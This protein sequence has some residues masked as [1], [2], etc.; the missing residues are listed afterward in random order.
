MFDTANPL[1]PLRFPV[2]WND[3]RPEHVDAAAQTHLER[4]RQALEDLKRPQDP[5]SNPLEAVESALEDLEALIRLLRLGT[6]TGQGDLRELHARWLPQ[7]SSLRSRVYASSELYRALQA[8]LEACGDDLDALQRRHLTL[9][10]ERLRREGAALSQEQRERLLAIDGRIA[11]LSALFGQNVTDDANR[12]VW[13]FPDD[14]RLAGLPPHALE[15]AREEAAARG[16]E[17][18]LLSLQPH[19]LA[20]VLDHAEDAELR[21]E[22]YLAD[23]STATCDPHDNRPILS[24]MLALRAEKAE[25]LGYPSYADLLLAD[26]MAGNLEAALA[27]EERLEQ[28]LRPAFERERDDL[29]R[30]RRR[31]EGEAAPEPQAWDLRFYAERLRRERFDFDD[32]VLRPYFELNAVLEGLFDLTRELFGVQVRRRRDLPVWHPDVEVF[33]LQD[34]GAEPGRDLAHIYVDLFARRGKAP[35]ACLEELW[36][37]ERSGG[38]HQPHVGYLLAEV[39][40][41]TA[42]QPALLGWEDVLT[43]FHEFGHLLHLALSNV[44][45]RALGGMRVAWDFMELPSQ[46]LENWCWEPEALARFAR[47]Y[48]RAEPIP[49]ALLSRLRAARSFRNATWSMRQVAQGRM[50]LELHGHYRPGRDGDPV[51]FSRRLRE[52]FV[53][54][55]LDPREQQLATFGH[56]F[57]E[58]V[59]YAAGYYAYKWA[60]VLDAD[61]FTRFR[62]EGILNAQT[63][64]DFRR[65]ILERGNA[66]DPAQLYRAFMGRDPD[67]QALL[68]RSGLNEPLPA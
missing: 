28:D 20:A 37:G 47:H 5:R 6:Q 14:A 13:H 22:L 11:E 48:E 52:R 44:P 1:L 18:Y 60:E 63:G 9:T 36:L 35:G 21:R 62:N 51:A 2:P 65:T 39:T 8:H 41:P 16:L 31:L 38:L 54:A 33:T 40:P 17:G 32:E 64:R 15:A 42:G 56:L 53:P 61:A 43:L 7:A 3:L 12:P 66:E 49:E 57:D 27:F 24:E 26:R 45:V 19:L 29:I 46:L 25:L 59:G 23:A 50:D 58:P 55:P 67:P 68:E 4:A 30:F 34:A 10:L